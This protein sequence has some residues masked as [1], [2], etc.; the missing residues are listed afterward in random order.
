M[1]EKYF[2]IQRTKT[3]DSETYAVAETIK[4]TEK[5]AR[6][7]YHQILASVYANDKIEYAVVKIDNY[8]GNAVIMENIIPQPPEPENE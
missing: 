3:S 1:E 7:V 2:V 6:I 8:Y 4:D 5:E